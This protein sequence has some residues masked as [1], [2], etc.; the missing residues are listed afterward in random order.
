MR[1]NKVLCEK[2][3][4]Q[5]LAHHEALGYEGITSVSLF[6]ALTRSFLLAFIPAASALHLNPLFF[7][8][9]GHCPGQG[10]MEN[11]NVIRESDSF[12]EKTSHTPRKASEGDSPQGPSLL[13]GAL[14]QL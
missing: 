13:W 1:I 6:T 9:S 10:I 8:L 3:L 4:A 11:R 12:Q 2:H 5:R 14:S 7:L